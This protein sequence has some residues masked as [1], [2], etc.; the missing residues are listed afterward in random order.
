MKYIG[1]T[2]RFVRAPFVLEGIILGIIGAAIPLA[3]LYVIYNQTIRFILTRYSS[4][5]GALR[6]LSA[7]N[8]YRTLG[9]VA[10]ALGM[11]IGLVGSFWTT[12]KHLRV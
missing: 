2:D 10:L 3:G 7:E 6:F 5:S 11:G 12:R 9:P 8:I 1:S 4:L